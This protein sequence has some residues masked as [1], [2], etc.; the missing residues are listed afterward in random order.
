MTS[1]SSK[2][3]RKQ[4]KVAV[5]VVPVTRSPPG[6]AV[7]SQGQS[8]MSCLHSY[9][10]H[11]EGGAGAGCAVGVLLRQQACLACC[12]HLV[13]SNLITISLW[14]GAAG[15]CLVQLQRAC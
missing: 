7:Q 14:F 12:L 9:E 15:V 13:G 4:A 3:K 1:S 10:V 2:M 11:D 5:L 6:M 8:V